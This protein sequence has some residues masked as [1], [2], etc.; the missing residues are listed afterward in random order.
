PADILELATLP[1]PSTPVLNA[2]EDL[3]Q[4]V[5]TGA[6]LN[7]NPASGAQSYQIQVSEDAEFTSTMFDQNGITS[8]SA[9]PDG[10][11]FGT[12]YYWRVR[13]TNTAGDGDWSETWSF[14]TEESTES[15]SIPEENM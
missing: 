8:T 12:A 3:A 14:T 11:D 6:S 5:P 2:P 4:E 1:P 9:V 15:N 10:L 7:W 13:A